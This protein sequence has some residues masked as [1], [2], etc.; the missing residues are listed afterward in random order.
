MEVYEH[1]MCCP[2]EP[3][4]RRYLALVAQADHSSSRR[5]VF[6]VA[7]LWAVGRGLRGGVHAMST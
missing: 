2:G 5:P 7:M 4:D 3:C 1:V 6:T